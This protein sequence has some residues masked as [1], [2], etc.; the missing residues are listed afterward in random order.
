MEKNVNR[1]DDMDVQLFTETLGRWYRSHGRDLPWRHTTDPYRIWISEIMLQQTQVE[2]VKGYYER[3]IRVF[4]DTKTLAK[5]GEDEVFKQW[6]GLGYYRRAK[7]LM[8]AAKTVE[9]E[10]G[11]KFPDTYDG[12]LRLKGVGMYTAS[13]IASIAYGIKKGVIDGNTLRI[14]SRIYNRQD[15]IALDKTKKVYQEIMDAMAAH[16]DPSEFNQAMMDLGAT[17]C[18]PRRAKCSEC[19]VRNFCLA[20]KHHTVDILPVNIKK[21][22]KTECYY[23]TAVLKYKDKYM[24]VKNKDGLLENLYGLVQYEAESPAAFEDQFYD[25]YHVQVRLLEYAK[26]IKH[27]FTHKVWHMNAYFGRLDEALDDERFLYTKDELMALPI[28]TAH[29]KVLKLFI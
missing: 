10:M 12:L 18:T 9:Y 13:A 25:T 20:L 4:P 7:H 5:A 22:S 16:T 17:I 19:P 28:S 29:Q 8:E 24:I 15:N 6:E 14:I 27:V 23:I 3:F 11:G 21:R 2:T 26:E 1:Q